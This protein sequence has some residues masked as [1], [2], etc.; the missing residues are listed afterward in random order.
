MNPRP[1]AVAL[2]VGVILQLVMVVAGHAL[3][4]VKDGFAIG[5]M[6]FSLLAG[7]IYVRLARSGWADTLIG[8]AIAGGGCALVG[9][10]VSVALKDAP[11]SLLALG[12][13]SSVVTGL[14]GAAAVRAFSPARG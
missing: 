10:A 8:G 5:G 14:I 13:A 2:G 12:T 4:W 1:L 6:G 3:P 7:L 9:I 11:A